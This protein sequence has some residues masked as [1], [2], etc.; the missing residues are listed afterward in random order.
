MKTMEQA[1]L[2]PTD[3]A[4]AKAAALRRV[5][6]LVMR[7][8]AEGGPEKLVLDP[9]CGSRMFWFDAE[10]ERVL[11]ADC[12]EEHVEV[13]DRSHGRED[14]TRS[15]TVA[16][17]VVAD[18]RELPFPDGAFAHVVFDPPHLL[19][20]GPESW[21]R[22]KYGVLDAATW[23]DDL[24]R[25]FA[26]CFRVLMPLGTLIFKWNETQIPV[27]DVLALTDRKPLYGHRSGKRADTHWIAFLNA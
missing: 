6:R 12:R 1:T 23:R 15:I 25:G 18:F 3:E 21:M 5:E 20:A 19:R 17:D 27:R 26:E 7:S 22:A 2:F 4:H 9:C 24:R 13:T 10:D 8:A 11:F 16:P 14:G